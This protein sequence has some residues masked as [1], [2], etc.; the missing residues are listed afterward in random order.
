MSEMQSCRKICLKQQTDLHRVLTN[1]KPYDQ[2]IRLFLR[3]HAMLHSAQVARTQL[4]SLEDAVLEDITENQMRSIVAGCPH[5]V[6]WIIWHMT[7]CEDITMN[8]LVAGC[9]QVLNDRWLGRM[10]VAVCDTGNTMNEQEIADFSHAINIKALRAYRVA[11]GRRTQAIVKRLKPADLK[12]QVDPVRLRQVTIEGAVL[13]GARGIVIYW[14][15]R[16]VAGLLLMPSTRHI[17]VHLN[18]VIRMKGRLL[19]HGS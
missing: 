11:V 6:A 13:E 14:G 5:S 7:R 17:L 2:A 15:R 8:L 10:K 1:A 18:E 4:E 3:Q 9:P 12:R 19:R 16:N